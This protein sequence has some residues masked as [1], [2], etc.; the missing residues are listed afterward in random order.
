ML[1]VTVILLFIYFFHFEICVPN[2]VSF[3]TT[4]VLWSGLN[5]GLSM[6]PVES[7]ISKNLAIN[8]NSFKPGVPFM[9]HRQAE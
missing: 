2:S 9:G 1:T 6:V 5:D 7:V 4:S 8:I 3:T